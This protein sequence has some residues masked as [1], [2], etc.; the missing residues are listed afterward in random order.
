MTINNKITITGICAVALLLSSQLFS[1]PAESP[2]PTST[3]T[4]KTP[5]EQIKQLPPQVLVATVAPNQQA[6]PK[7]A[8]PS[9]ATDRWTYFR[10][11]ALSQGVANT[12]LPKKPVL[13]WKYEVPE[14][15]FEVT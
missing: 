4:S 13:L 9:A 15:A 5:R 12:T 3:P 2:Q 11:N 14:G 8:K 7:V 10:G 6:N 1:T